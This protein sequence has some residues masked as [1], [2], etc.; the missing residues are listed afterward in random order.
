[1]QHPYRA[2]KLQP[3]R[4]ETLI[5]NT[6][7]ANT[8]L[9]GLEKALAGKLPRHDRA[10]KLCARALLYEALGDRKMLETAQEA[11]AF[12]KTAQTAQILAVALHYFGRVEESIKMH[13]QAYRYPHEPGFEIDID[14][15]LSLLYRGKWPEARK[16]LLNMKKRMVYAGH[17]PDWRGEKVPEISI[18]GEGGFGDIINYARWIPKI[19]E[20]GI[21]PTLYLSPYMYDNSFKAL[22]ESQSWF[23]PIKRLVE[24]PLK[25]PAT[26]VFDLFAVFDAMPGTL[27]SP[28]PWTFQQKADLPTGKPRVALCWSAQSTESPLMAKGVYRSLTEEQVSRL[29][30]ET[31]DHVEWVNLQWGLDT[32]GTLNLSQKSWNDTAT[33][34]NSVDAVVTIDTFAVHLAASMGKPVW[35]LLSGASDWRW[36]IKGT[37]TEW[38]PTV[39]IFRNNDFGFENALNN[40]IAA[41]TASELKTNL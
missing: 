2:T 17:L 35:M 34:I 14:Y 24:T 15:A 28:A 37:T 36:G 41:I 33:I 22:C 38:Y 12:S 26:G 30:S 23:C 39:R 6:D 10:V 29:I 19:Y 20:M 13:E 16:I 27:P 25:V 4:G 3:Q 9:A 40:L 1:M 11:Y 31:R 21:K 8:T 5:H 18:V 7:E 32:P